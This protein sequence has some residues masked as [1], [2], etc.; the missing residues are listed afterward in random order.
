M[1]NKLYFRIREDIF[2]GQRGVSVVAFQAHQ[3]AWPLAIRA[4]ETWATDSGAKPS[5]TQQNLPVLRL[6]AALQSMRSA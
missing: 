5:R 6:I 3:P 2:R 1:G 4:G